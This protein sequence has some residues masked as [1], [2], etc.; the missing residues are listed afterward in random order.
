LI[1]LYK[2]SDKD[3]FSQLHGYRF[4]VDYKDPVNPWLKLQSYIPLIFQQLLTPGGPDLQ[5]R[6]SSGEFEEFINASAF[7][8]L[9]GLHARIVLLFLKHAEGVLVVKE[10][11][12]VFTEIETHWKGVE[13]QLEQ[14][15]FN[16]DQTFFVNLTLLIESWNTACL[17]AACEKDRAWK[18]ILLKQLKQAKK[19][20]SKANTICTSE[21]IVAFAKRSTL[22]I[23]QLSV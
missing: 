20:L 18:A 4:P 15:F 11:E 12:N 7:S 14:K 8:P 2:P 5:I 19:V 6:A 21:T 16:V 3:F 9:E 22:N 17:F 10:M 13:S 1:A 23:P